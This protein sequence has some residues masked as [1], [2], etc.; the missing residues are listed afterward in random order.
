ML[1][2]YKPRHLTLCVAATLLS[3][4]SAM[5]HQKSLSNFNEMLLQGDLEQ[6]KDYALERADYDPETGNVDDLLWSIQ[7]GTL[8]NKTSQ[9]QLSTDVLDASERLMRFEDTESTLSQTGESLGATLGNDAMLDYEASHFEG[10]MVNTLKAWNFWAQGEMN[11]ARVEFNRANDRERRAI[12]YFGDEVKRDKESLNAS[13][14][15]GKLV[16]QATNSKNMRYALEDGGIFTNQWQPYHGYANPLVSYSHGLFL[17]LNAQSRSDYNTAINSLERAYGMS[18]AE[19]IKADIQLA[20]AM[21]KRPQSTIE[22]QVWVIFENGQSIIKEEK[23]LDLPLFLA[24]GSISYAGGSLPR[25]KQRQIAYPSISVNQQNTQLLSDMDK[26]IASEFDQQFPSILTREITRMTVKAAGQALLSQ[27]SE[28]LEGA[29][30]I[31]SFATTGADVRSLSAL[32]SQYQITRVQ[33]TSDTVSLQVGH[34]RYEVPVEGGSNHMIWVSA[35]R[36]ASKPHF[37]VIDL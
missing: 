27:E 25:L 36:P 12:E 13:G 30:A 22:N 6:A 31:Y 29:G 10:V 4:C 9:Y 1:A 2:K 8:L 17:L 26:V 14:I 5:S 11:N 35:A 16:S 33:K 37:T 21:K 34:Y 19:S 24:G 15:I 3:G 23:R 32:P 28:W 18:G 20:K 7:A